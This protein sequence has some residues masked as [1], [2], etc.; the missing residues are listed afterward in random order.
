MKIQDEKNYQQIDETSKVNK[1]PS[2]PVC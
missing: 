2:R 1:K